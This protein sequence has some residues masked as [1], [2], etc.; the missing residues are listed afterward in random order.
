MSRTLDNPDVTQEELEAWA[1]FFREISE[2]V[3]SGSSSGANP[4]AALGTA[5]IELALTPAEAAAR[6]SRVIELLQT[7]PGGLT[8]AR[9]RERLIPVAGALIDILPEPQRTTFE[10]ALAGSIFRLSV[11][12]LVPELRPSARGPL[13]VGVLGAG[14]VGCFVGGCL[15]STGLCRV[16]MVGRESLLRTVRATAMDA[17]AGEDEDEDAAAKGSSDQKAAG[18]ADGGEA[19]GGFRRRGRKGGAPAASPST[20][21]PQSLPAA[22]GPAAAAAAASPAAA[23]AAP[24]PAAD[25]VAGPHISLQDADLDLAVPVAIFGDEE[26]KGDETARAGAIGLG[27][28][29]GEPGLVMT[30]SLSALRDV[31]VVL[32]CV[33][34][35]DTRKAVGE[36]LA[37]WAPRLSIPST[38]ARPSASSTS[39]SSSS[40]AAAAAAGDAL[41][42]VAARHASAGLSLDAAEP[43]G[44]ADDSAA[45]SVQSAPLAPALAAAPLA[46]SAPPPG[47][48]TAAGASLDAAASPA[49]AGSS[50]G[51][52]P[53]L[54]VSLQNGVDNPRVMAALAGADRCDIAAG[55]VEFNVVAEGARFAK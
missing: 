25:P 31:D 29:A 37:L 42:G 20:S 21:P 7:H 33:K 52:A 53:P 10:S 15:A 8:L 11:P 50:S 44:V 26:A 43:A 45:L 2:A 28:G 5:G 41:V 14:A 12:A 6:A 18:V 3:V 17:R 49:C 55:I 4:R 19:D 13:R 24:P 22:E 48:A 47:S 34:S 27:A 40:T 51:R 46:A 35:T 30:T 36:L 1:A 23:V 38:P 39:A 16:V 9:T 54:L 32:V